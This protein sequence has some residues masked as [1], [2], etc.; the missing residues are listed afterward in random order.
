MM[1]EFVWQKKFQG[2]VVPADSKEFADFLPMGFIVRSQNKAYR[3]PVWE[4]SSF[5]GERRMGA[6]K[7]A[8]R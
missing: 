4:M 1:N 3:R 6:F 5:G 8:E 7:A 2:R